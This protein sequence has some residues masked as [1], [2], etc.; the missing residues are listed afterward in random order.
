ML[1]M[2]VCSKVKKPLTE[3]QETIVGD[4]RQL[5]HLMIS[6]K[7]LKG[8]SLRVTCKSVVRNRRFQ[9]S[10]LEMK[11]RMFSTAQHSSESQTDLSSR[12]LSS[13]GTEQFR[14]ESTKGLNPL[15]TKMHSCIHE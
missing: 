3:K 7:T 1:R 4:R 6:R 5:A 9:K 13:L 10:A 14:D 15:E 8:L 11:I 2:Q 12:S